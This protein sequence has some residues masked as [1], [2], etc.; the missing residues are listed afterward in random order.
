MSNTD[1]YIAA[2]DIVHRLCNFRTSK[3]IL[4]LRVIIST[5][6]AQISDVRSSPGASGTMPELVTKYPVGGMGGGAS[7]ASLGNV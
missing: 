4:R 6:N 3:I 2:V 5:T 7:K 1:K